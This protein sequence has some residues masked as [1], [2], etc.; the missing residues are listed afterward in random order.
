MISMHSNIQF[1]DKFRHTA[2]LNLIKDAAYI[3]ISHMLHLSVD[4]KRISQQLQLQ[5][6][7][8]HGEGFGDGV[9][10]FETGGM[11]HN[12]PTAVKLEAYFS[13]LLHTSQTSCLGWLDRLG[14]AMGSMSVLLMF[15]KESG[16]VAS[17]FEQS[18]AKVILRNWSPDVFSAMYPTKD[19]CN[20]WDVRRLLY[21]QNTW[22][23]L[24]CKPTEYCGMNSVAP[25]NC[26]CVCKM[27]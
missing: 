1:S 9:L 23:I 3:S 18:K 8:C 11:K 20:I 26:G 6:W 5:L 16:Q 22:M 19:S 7:C 13:V 27:L 2:Q 17:R 25:A 12:T 24:L 15:N 14:S 21:M 10:Y 4:H